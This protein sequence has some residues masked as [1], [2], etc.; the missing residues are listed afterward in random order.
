MLSLAEQLLT[1]AQAYF[2]KGCRG[3]RGTLRY[4]H[5]Q[6]DRLGVSPVN[7]IYYVHLRWGYV[8][9]NIGWVGCVGIKEK[10]VGYIRRYSN[11][12]STLLPVQYLKW[13]YGK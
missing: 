2:K 11:V 9:S 1:Q 6:C 12:T 7:H 3:H 5:V 4:I 10:H 8:F 13:V